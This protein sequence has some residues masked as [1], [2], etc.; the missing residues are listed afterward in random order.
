MARKRQCRGGR[1]KDRQG[2]GGRRVAGLRRGDRHG[3][4]EAETGRVGEAYISVGNTVR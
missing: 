2:G 3:P 4:V 1:G